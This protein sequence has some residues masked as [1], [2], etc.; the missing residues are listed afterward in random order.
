[1]AITLSEAAARHL[2][3]SL[4]R[5]DGGKGI[6]LSLKPAGCSGFSYR[7]DYVEEASQG[8]AV[9]VQHGITLLVDSKDLALVDGTE[10]DYARSGL[11]DTLQF[12]NPNERDRCGCGESF[13]V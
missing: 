7:L 9:F 2:A 13:R 1:M 5:H 12:K 3:A 11:N 4:A 6:R 8:D 10:I